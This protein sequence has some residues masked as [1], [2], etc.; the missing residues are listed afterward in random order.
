MWKAIYSPYYE[1]EVPKE[2][3][4]IIEDIPD[5][6]RRIHARE[7]VIT[8]GKYRIMISNNK[9]VAV[10]PKP[11][12]IWIWKGDIV[13]KI[14]IDGSR[15]TI[16]VEKKTETKEETVIKVRQKGKDKNKWKVSVTRYNVET[17]IINVAGILEFKDIKRWKISD[18]VYKY[19]DA[20]KLGIIRG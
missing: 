19:D 15:E 17:T 10:S 3:G 9:I 1:I 5:L 18:V 8:R 11:S 6:V 2:G 4:I 14:N 13:E 12:H 20:V 16:P 7:A